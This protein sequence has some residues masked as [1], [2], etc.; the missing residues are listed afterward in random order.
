MSIPR[1]TKIIATLGPALKS[2]NALHKLLEAGVNLVR[3]NFSHGPA[4]NH[5]NF[6]SRVRSWS[7]TNKR[8]IGIIADLQG[9]KI[10]ITNFKHGTIVLE[11]GQEFILDNSCPPDDGDNLR[12][13]VTYAKLW[14]DVSAGDILLLDD[15]KIK[16][17]VLL[18]EQEAISTKVII[19]GAL[20]NGKGV[21]LAGGGISAPALSDKD[22]NDIKLATELGV[23][24][25]ALSFVASAKDIEETRELIKSHNG[26]AGIIA[27]IERA[28]AESELVNIIA[29]AD[30]VMVARGDLALEVGAENVPAWQNKIITLSKQAATPVI[31]A[32]QMM[33]SMINSHSP[34][35]AEVSDVAY[36]VTDGVDAVMLSAETAVGTHPALVIKTMAAICLN[37]EQNRTNDS[38]ESLPLKFARTDQAIAAMAAITATKLD[39]KGVVALTESGYTALWMSH[40]GIK[41][42]IY[43]LSRNQ[44]SLNKMTLYRGVLPLWFEFSPNNYQDIEAEILAFLITETSL[45]KNDKVIITRGDNVGINGQANC[46]KILHLT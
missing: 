9:P 22:K 1:L 33:E 23:D 13:G 18:S 30:G 10:R 41:L 36:A 7:A 39:V 32:T 8:T 15:G 45:K 4:S 34:T 25:I 14:Q 27:K 17:Q 44:E 29:A 16:L 5:T 19:G 43:G 26:T 2:E 12:V 20:S 31:V 11:P 37:A 35:R 46:M 40:T 6:V 38:T 28:D 3:L 42:P 24:Y 21:N